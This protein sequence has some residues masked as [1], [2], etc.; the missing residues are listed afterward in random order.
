MKKV[1][2]STA[3]NLPKSAEAKAKLE[4]A[5]RH[6]HYTF[7]TLKLRQAH[8]LLECIKLGLDAGIVVDDQHVSGEEWMDLIRTLID[9][10]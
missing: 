6:Q 5:V 7:P 4:A 8:I 3:A 1:D 2:K 10:R 9:V